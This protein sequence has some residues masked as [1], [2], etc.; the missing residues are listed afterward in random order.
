MLIHIPLYTY[1]TEILSENELKEMLSPLFIC[2]YSY[3]DSGNYEPILITTNSR[4]ILAEIKVFRKNSGFDFNCHF[5][6]EQEIIEV[7][8]YSRWHVVNDNGNT[9][10]KIIPLFYPIL[11]KL[12]EHIIHVNYNTMFLR[13]YDF[14]YLKKKSI[15]FLRNNANNFH[16]NFDIS[17]LSVHSSA[18]D[19]CKKEIIENYFNNPP[20]EN[21]DNDYKE[22]PI[23]YLFTTL[24]DKSNELFH[25]EKNSNHSLQA[26]QL[27]FHNDWTQSAKL[28]NYQYLK[29]MQFP[30]S[31]HGI[32]FYFPF[33]ECAKYLNSINIQFYK[34]LIIWYQYFLELNTIMGG[35][36]CTIL[37]D[38][39]N[40]TI[41][42]L[43]ID[44]FGIRHYTELNKTYN[45]Q[46]KTGT[47]PLKEAEE[48]NDEFLKNKKRNFYY[49]L[50]NENWKFKSVY[51]N[52]YCN[53]DIG[54]VGKLG[55]ENKQIALHGGLNT[56][57]FPVLENYTSINFSLEFYK[58][59][60]VHIN[61][62]NSDEHITKIEGNNNIA[63]RF[64]APDYVE[65]NNELIVNIFESYANTDSLQ[66]KWYYDNK[67]CGNKE[68]NTFH[69]DSMGWHEIKLELRDNTNLSTYIKN[70]YVFEHV[71]QQTPITELENNNSN[72][73][74]LKTENILL[75]KNNENTDD[76]NPRTVTVEL[77][78]M[79]SFPLSGK[80][81]YLNK[82]TSIDGWYCSHEFEVLPLSELKWRSSLLLTEDTNVKIKY[83]YK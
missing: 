5:V 26:S 21:S 34:S 8:G 81:K 29:P 44:N 12:D 65:L 1:S 2:I 9:I 61:A 54:Y 83:W 52:I 20:Q 80:I 76:W 78:S 51:L 15:T 25:I 64:R 35:Y 27:E 45:K 37:N 19:V 67:E 53:N 40:S 10:L 56:I 43:M 70:I 50:Q 46:K 72:I 79:D 57:K 82:T 6:S 62:W 22:Y 55:W 39:S 31:D 14:T 33:E 16:D 23:E 38:L 77:Q 41:T 42:N 30:L 17:L 71:N 13:K 24:L 74:N 3:Y 69:F 63:A 28:I 47:V 73:Y 49:Y 66:I 7:F 58:N 48:Y 18:F 36:F 32:N 75:I 11:K 4:Q 68:I 59:I 60:N